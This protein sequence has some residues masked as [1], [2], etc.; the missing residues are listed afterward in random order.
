MFMFKANQSLSTRSYYEQNNSKAFAKILIE[1]LRPEE[2]IAAFILVASKINVNDFSAELGKTQALAPILFKYVAYKYENNAE[3]C[4]N[5]IKS[6][7][8]ALV[9]PKI[10]GCWKGYIDDT[11]RLAGI[12][13][14]DNIKNH[15][16]TKLQLND[17]DL[18]PLPGE[19][20]ITPTKAAIT[21]QLQNLID[22]FCAYLNQDDQSHW[23]FEMKDTDYFFHSNSGDIKVISCKLKSILEGIRNAINTDNL[24]LKKPIRESIEGIHNK[25]VSE[26]I[27]YTNGSITRY[28]HLEC[29]V[30]C[31]D[32]LLNPNL[33]HR[34]FGQG[35]QQT[36]IKKINQIKEILKSLGITLDLTPIPENE[37]PKTSDNADTDI[38]PQD[39]PDPFKYFRC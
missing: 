29:Y 20:S 21:T 22:S 14:F 36:L 27:K 32:P 11:K 23:H 31:I 1:N 4:K 7:L 25:L 15:F 26:D 17:V 5:H 33:P 19:Q 16:K 10:D 6:Q 12:E 39:P 37:D 2:V 24:Q 9:H 8:S 13:E 18:S 35:T 38:A 28:Q 30:A 3:A 34:F